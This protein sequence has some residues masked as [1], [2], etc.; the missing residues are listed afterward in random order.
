[1]SFIRLV[2]STLASAAFTIAALGQSTIRVEDGDGSPVPRSLFSVGG[3][4]LYVETDA[5]GNLDVSGCGGG[6]IESLNPFYQRVTVACDTLGSV[7]VLAP[8]D[9]PRV[10]VEESRVNVGQYRVNAEYVEAFPALLGEPDVLKSLQSLPGVSGAGEG[11]VAPLIRGGSADQSLILLDGAELFSPAHAVG[12]LGA[13]NY[14][15]VDEA[16]VYT[17]NFPV[18]YG[19]RLS[20]IV[21]VTSRTPAG[22]FWHL[23]AGAG[24]PNATFLAEGPLGER[25]SALTSARITYPSLLL[26]FSESRITQGDVFAKL[27]HRLSDGSKAA[28]T[29]YANQDRIAAI[30]REQIAGR[31]ETLKSVLQWG[32]IVSTAQW[33]RPVRGGL[34]KASASFSSYESGGFARNSA[35]H[36]ER[37]DFP[38]STR[39]TLAAS[40][41]AREVSTWRG[42]SVDVSA[43][44]SHDRSDVSGT[45]ASNSGETAAEAFPLSS[46][47]IE[48]G[49][50]LHQRLGV[51]TTATLGFRGLYLRLPEAGTE[52]LLDPRLTISRT[53]G[54]QTLSIS[55]DAMSQPVHQLSVGGEEAYYQVFLSPSSAYP[56]QRASQVSVTLVGKPESRTYTWSVGAYRKSLRNLVFA[57]DGVRLLPTLQVADPLVELQD[58]L[59]YGIETSLALM[60]PRSASALFNYSYSRSERW[61]PTDRIADPQPF[62]WERPHTLRATITQQVT[63]RWSTTGSF[64]YQSGFHFSS[65][66][67][68]IGPGYLVDFMEPVFQQ[69]Y[70][71]RGPAAHRLDLSATR[72]WVTARFGH[73]LTLSVYNAYARRNPF[74]LSFD[75]FLARSSFE[76]GGRLYQ[77]IIDNVSI[78]RFIPGIYYRLEF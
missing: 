57:P 8:L 21:D 56:T 40:V 47:R 60:L 15:Y 35:A 63:P 27:H 59:A 13:I 67:Y 10:V 23:E 20:G 39:N 46:Q 14:D 28:L 26:S 18:H 25:T 45:A 78:L 62:R 3:G 5:I 65:P 41:S 22:D 50:A 31:D 11:Q 2:V 54:S 72:N 30:E 1:M 75:R 55:Y 44:F 9:L 34:L 77:P 24:V 69:R 58:G 32:N 68:L 48:Y 76:P 52:T 74:S 37:S 42:A 29:V 7:L 64:S 16:Q 70:S 6:V 53:F 51:N 12:Y 36:S 33:R 49:V 71:G 43:R 66:S 4:T 19:G 17:S 73:R 38:G 61:D